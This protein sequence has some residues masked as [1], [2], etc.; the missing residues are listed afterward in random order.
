MCFLKWHTLSPV[1]LELDYLWVV[2]LHRDVDLGSER[3][4]GL[5][6]YFNDFFRVPSTDSDSNPFLGIRHFIRHK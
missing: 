3:A 1:I 4:M 5:F 6:D 2:I